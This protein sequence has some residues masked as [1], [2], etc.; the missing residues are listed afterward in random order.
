MHYLC[1]TIS[2]LDT[3]WGLSPITG[4]FYCFALGARRVLVL[5]LLL[6]ILLLTPDSPSSSPEWR[7]LHAVCFLASRVSFLIP[8]KSEGRQNAKDDISEEEK[9]CI[10]SVLPFSVMSVFRC[11]DDWFSLPLKSSLCFWVGPPEI[12]LEPFANIFFLI[13]FKKVIKK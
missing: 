13:P 3:F 12:Q 11:S 7:C 6:I 4:A 10:L 1:Q 5:L 2:R 9:I 8:G